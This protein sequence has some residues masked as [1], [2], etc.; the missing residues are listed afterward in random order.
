MAEEFLKEF[1]APPDTNVPSFARGLEILV[2]DDDALSLTYISSL[3]EE[4]SYKVTT[5]EQASVALSMLR[6]PEHNF[7]LVIANVTMDNLS[8]LHEIKQELPVVVMSTDGNVVNRAIPEGAR[9]FLQKPMQLKALKPV[10]QYADWNRKGKNIEIHL[11]NVEENG[12]NM[13]Q[14]Q[15]IRINETT[16]LPMLPMEGNII[17]EASGKFR[18][19]SGG[20][21]INEIGDSLCPIDAQKPLGSGGSLLLNTGCE[22][23]GNLITHPFGMILERMQN[24][25]KTTIVTDDEDNGFRNT[26]T[27]ET[28][29]ANLKR[30][31]GGIEGNKEKK[32]I[33]TNLETINSGSL[34]INGDG[35]KKNGG[36]N[37]TPLRRT[38]V[39]SPELHQ[40]F[41]EAFEALGEEFA[42]PRM[43]QEKM[44]V[45]GITRLQ[46]GSHLQKYKAEKKK[47]NGTAGITSSPTENQP[48]C[49]HAKTASAPP[50]SGQNPQISEPGKGPVNFRA[51]GTS[52]SIIPRPPTQPELNR[53]GAELPRLNDAG[54]KDLLSLIKS[55]C[56]PSVFSLPFER[57]NS[58]VS[59]HG[60]G[61]KPLNFGVVGTSQ[62]IILKPPTQPEVNEHR[63][64][65]G[66]INEI[67]ALRVPFRGQSSSSHVGISIS[68]SSERPSSLLS[69]NGEGSLNSRVAGNTIILKPQTQLEANVD[70]YVGNGQRK[71]HQ[72]SG[73]MGSSSNSNSYHRHIPNEAHIESH[74]MLENLSQRRTSSFDMYEKGKGKQPLKVKGSV[75][76]PPRMNF[77]NVLFEP[78][79]T[80]APDKS[81]GT[82]AAEL[83]L[84]NSN[85]ATPKTASPYVLASTQASELNLSSLNNAH[86][87]AASPY[88]SAGT[89]ASELNMPNS[90]YAPLRVVSPY[91]P[92]GTQASELNLPNPNYAPSMVASPYVS[93]GTQASELNLPN[94]NYAPPRGASPYLSAGTQA[95]ELNLQNPNYAPSRAASPYVSAGTQASELN[96]PNSNYA[97]PRAASPYLSAGTQA[98]ELNLPIPNY[99]P[100]RAASPYVSNGTK[101]S[102]LNLSNSN[103]APPRAAFPYVSAGTQASEL[104]LSN[105][106]Y[107]PPRA[108][109]PY[110]S[111]GT[112]SSESNLPN[113][114]YAPLGAASPYVSV[115]TQ[116]SELNLPNSNY[117]PPKVVSPY[118]SADTQASELNLPNS[119]YA[120]PRVTSPYVSTSTQASELNLPNSNYAPPRAASPY[121][122]A[123]TQVSELNLP[124]PNYAPPRAASPFVSANTQASQVSSENL[125]YAP[126]RG[127][128]T[129]VANNLANSSYVPPLAS[130]PHVTAGAQVSKMNLHNSSY[131]APRIPSRYMVAGTQV[132]QV[133]LPMSY[134]PPIEPTPYVAADTRVSELK[135]PNSSYA[136]PSA[137]PPYVPTC[138]QVPE[139]NLAYSS[140]APPMAPS[141]FVSAYTGASEMNISSSTNMPEKAPS[142]YVPAG[143]L[144]LPDSPILLDH[145]DNFL[146]DVASILHSQNPLSIGDIGS[147]NSVPPLVT[148][149]MSRVT[150]EVVNSTPVINSCDAIQTLHQIMNLAP[151][152]N[153]PS[154]NQYLFSEYDDILRILDEDAANFSD[155]VYGPNLDADSLELMKKNLNRK[156][157]N[158]H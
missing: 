118:V 65:E 100:S 64:E 73:Q 82:Q 114:N 58:A 126:L 45:E 38:R 48:I 115:G 13:M 152:A 15:G 140:H 17:K 94:S 71:L 84:S 105:S 67:A 80:P 102:E 151:E 154:Q 50:F 24:K 134:A 7:R 98:F 142:P 66:R 106:N 130:S 81:A 137:P 52:Q 96:L 3:L 11:E 133:N 8:N 49:S 157:A 156:N 107:A 40:K 111:V 122:P 127:P 33:K 121:L 2:V 20:I 42:N 141:P 5:A 139:T 57:R 56:R 28:Q 68:P 77:P 116:A 60:H 31:L 97:S 55:Y 117:V 89:Q 135:L 76:R 78:P 103:Y 32:K 79:T 12:N 74:G 53:N 158:Q 128:C 1:A 34:T 25:G 92:A 90:N 70:S 144:R 35:K 30:P 110:L 131:A 10:W 41:V 61:W 129:Y 14:P 138:V 87:R 145:M 112:Q 47:K 26:K 21:R 125:S 51:V 88:V 36:K 109:S 39:W 148:T 132:P 101:A 155:F 104:N 44:N 59:Q 119:N 69:H 120:P 153:S 29:G 43:I 95:S 63:N 16:T 6:E 108:A 62:S 143:V 54:N 72:Y 149:G 75:T 93:A 9:Y 37:S 23:H 18:P 136:A 124:N 150:N 4:Y 113:P 123:D 147:L 19:P 46:I 99:A 91:L 27:S 146:E 86:P 22:Y 85:Y 83:N